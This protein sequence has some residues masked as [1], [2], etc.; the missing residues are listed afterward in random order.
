MAWYLG[1]LW[2]EQ[3]GN[4]SKDL[5]SLGGL[6]QAARSNVVS[7]YRHTDV[8]ITIPHEYCRPCRLPKRVHA[9][10]CQVPRLAGNIGWR[11]Q[12]LRPRGKGELP[13]LSPRGR[14]DRD[15]LA[16]R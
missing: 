11:E 1:L 5:L 4:G 3:S 7:V 10:T 14:F 12:R 8:H 16:R 15:W 6:T 9:A 13:W 2:L